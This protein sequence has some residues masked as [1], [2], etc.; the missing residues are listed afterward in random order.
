LTQ[1]TLGKWGKN[2][3]IRLPLEV[4]KATGLRTGEKVEVETRG[5]DIIIR[6]AD[7]DAA[8]DARAA[9]EEIIRESENYTLDAAEILD[10][11]KEGR[12]G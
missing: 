6:R 7:A 9:A 8:A 4:V 3:A 2:L 1:A 10:M 5:G 12:R 11:L